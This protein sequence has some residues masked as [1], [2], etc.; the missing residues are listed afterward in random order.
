MRFYNPVL[1][2]YFRTY[3]LLLT[4]ARAFELSLTIIRFLLVSLPLRLIRGERD[5]DLAPASEILRTGTRLDVRDDFGKLSY[6]REYWEKQRKVVREKSRYAPTSR[7]GWGPMVRILVEELGPTFIKLGQFMSVRPEVPISVQ[8]ELQ[9]LQERVPPFS[10]K[11]VAKAVRREF[12]VPLEEVYSQFEKKPFAA[13]SLAQ[14]HR[15]RLRREGEEV[16]V[17]V[18]RPYMEGIVSTDLMIIEVLLNILKIVIP[19]LRKKTDVGILMS[20][21]GGTLRKEIDFRIEA[22]AQERLQGWYYNNPYFKDYIRIPNLYGD[23]VTGKILTMELMRGFYRCDTEEYL[24]VCRDTTHVGIPKWDCN[25]WPLV[26]I[27]GALLMDSLYEAQFCYMDSH[28]GNIYFLPDEKKMLMLDYGMCEEMSLEQVN[29]VVDM[30]CAMYM[31]AS[32]AMMMESILCLHEFAG[33]KRAKIDT[34]RLLQGC[35]SWIERRTA[36]GEGDVQKRGSQDFT[37]DLLSFMAI[38]G[39][40]FPSFLW[41]F[42]KSASGLVRFGV[43]IDPRYDSLPFQVQYLGENIKRRMIQRIKSSDIVNIGDDIDVMMRFLTD[44]PDVEKRVP[45]IAAMKAQERPD[46]DAAKT[47]AKG[48]FDGR[49]LTI[50]SEGKGNQG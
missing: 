12:G 19:E 21:F 2:E 1:W 33:G 15:A 14:V 48:S 44:I 24:Q 16:A 25:Q 40:K 8:K 36:G 3:R 31:F 11:Q 34:N 50:D 28:L 30:L 47:M 6:E 35:T 10:Y 46:S 17:K 27:T 32:P 42:I 29:L 18:R 38:N 37:A 4:L 49:K 22:A 39:L 7:W 13:A 5:P 20:G 41:Y 9:R 43:L 26:N 23:Y 45:G